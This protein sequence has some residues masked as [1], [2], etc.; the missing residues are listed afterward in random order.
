M[1]HFLEIG[2]GENSLGKD[3]DAMDMVY[4]PHVNIQHDAR[5]FP[6][7]IPNRTYSIVYMSHILEHIRYIKPV[8]IDSPTLT[9]SLSLKTL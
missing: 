3:W 8:K 1:E 2:P 7:P 5:K 9:D 6:Y 4:R